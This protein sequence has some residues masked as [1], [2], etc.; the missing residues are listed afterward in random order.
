MTCPSCGEATIVTTDGEHLN[1]TPGRLGRHLKDGTVL[2]PDEIR[3]TTVRGYYPH[4]CTT[5]TPA[6][7]TSQASLF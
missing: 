2:A 4:H 6:A 3:N 7:T 1:P 5:T